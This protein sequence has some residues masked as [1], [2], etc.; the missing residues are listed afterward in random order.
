MALV[1]I[2]SHELAQTTL[3]L[4]NPAFNDDHNPNL[5]VMWRHMMDGSIYSYVDGTSEEALRYDFLVT[6]G[7]ENF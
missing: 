4:P 3:G 1:L 5:K 6:E 7:K 2:G